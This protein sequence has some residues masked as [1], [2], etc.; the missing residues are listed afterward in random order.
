MSEPYYFGRPPERPQAP[1]GCILRQF[2]LRCVNCRSLAL[3]VIGEQD[4]EGIKVYV[5]CTRCQAREPLP[6]R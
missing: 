1:P 3:K 5:H 2:E 6:V 4:D